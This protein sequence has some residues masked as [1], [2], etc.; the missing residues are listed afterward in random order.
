MTYQDFPSTAK[1]WIYQSNREFIEKERNFILS[2]SSD[3]LKNWNAHGSKLNACAEIF[4]NRFLVFFVDE[5]MA[6]ASGCSIDK[7]VHF[8][9]ELE[10]RLNLNFFDRLQIAYLEDEEVKTI[11]FSEINALSD[12]T[13]IFNNAVTSKLEWET[14]WKQPIRESWV[15]R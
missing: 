11:H 12:N 6:S 1:V 9:K 2:S 7:S 4:Y 3:F 15:V 5:T 8:V 14:S 10:Q 13:I